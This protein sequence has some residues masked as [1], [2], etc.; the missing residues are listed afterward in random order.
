[1]N[2]QPQKKQ[3]R[4]KSPT[5]PAAESPAQKEARTKD[6]R[7]LEVLRDS[8]P[9][10]KIQD[11]KH[12]VQVFDQGMRALF[13]NVGNTSKEDLRLAKVSA[14]AVA[15]HKN[16]DLHNVQINPEK[17]SVSPERKGP[18]QTPR[19]HAKKEFKKKETQRGSS[20]DTDFSITV[21]RT[22]VPKV[23]AKTRPNET[24]ALPRN[25]AERE[26]VRKIDE[27]LDG[28]ALAHMEPDKRNEIE[29]LLFHYDLLIDAA[30]G[31]E[32]RCNFKPIP[33]PGYKWKTLEFLEEFLAKNPG[34]H[35][36]IFSVEHKGLG[37][38]CFYIDDL[39][40]L[41]LLKSRSPTY[42]ALKKLDEENWDTVHVKAG[43]ITL[44]GAEILLAI[45]WAD[46][47]AKFKELIKDG[48]T[49]EMHASLLKVSTAIVPKKRLGKWRTY[50]NLFRRT[51]R[52][53]WWLFVAKL[54]TDI[55]SNCLCVFVLH[56][57]LFN[58]AG[59]SMGAL[60]VNACREYVIGW[61]IQ[62]VYSEIWK[63]L[64]K[65]SIPFLTQIGGWL[66]TLLKK[67]DFGISGDIFQAWVQAFASQKGGAVVSGAKFFVTAVFSKLLMSGVTTLF[68]GTAFAVGVFSAGTLVPIA[69]GAL[70][71]TYS[72]WGSSPSQ[73]TLQLSAL[74]PHAANLN[75]I[76]L[77]TMQLASEGVCQ[78]VGYFASAKT[79][80]WCNKKSNDF[81]RSMFKYSIFLTVAD[82]LVFLVR[83]GYGDKKFW[84]FYGPT[85]C[86]L[87]Y[88][89]LLLKREQQM[90]EAVNGAVEALSEINERRADLAELEH[91]KPE[92][93]SEQYDA[94]LS[95]LNKEINS[96]TAKYESN[97]A[98]M[99]TVQGEQAH[100]QAAPQ[101]DSRL[102]IEAIVSQKLEKL[103]DKIDEMQRAS[104]AA[105]DLLEI[106]PLQQEQA[107]L[108][109]VATE[110]VAQNLHQYM[111]G[112]T[113][114]PNQLS[115]LQR[116]LASSIATL[117]SFEGAIA[118]THSRVPHELIRQKRAD[119][120]HNINILQK[121]MG[122]QKDES[123]N[124]E[125]QTG[126]ELMLSP[127]WKWPVYQFL[128]PL[129]PE[130]G[131]V[132]AIIKASL[133]DNKGVSL[134][135]F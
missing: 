24:G 103:N 23:K 43:G 71:V 10:E 27:A 7:F 109:R 89:N 48:M 79:V 55:L 54:A 113:I 92:I 32:Y 61:A 50:T 115:E 127:G 60:F 67:L 104:G 122:K 44:S 77:L 39:I 91:K 96:I 120:V 111:A 40:Q 110:H 69:L 125:K 53:M 117:K 19:K 18:V 3:S 72:R 9:P 46:A 83:V 78:I 63:I 128:C 4:K 121:R 12:K 133:N 42:D 25:K 56:Y 58:T 22:N 62:V 119:A 15:R 30:R 45:Q 129:N 118:T 100:A 13:T 80:R 76:N 59:L 41:L 37:L 98:E 70:F 106:V 123:K 8:E 112:S 49:P 35:L 74:T 94:K 47:Y 99:Q 108:Q 17:Q 130:P 90:N 116:K 95:L 28:Y 75:A 33:I 57:S 2:R 51:M 87:Q 93:P 38:C 26:T 6:E 21:Q 73:E 126:Y 34:N 86:E 66:S 101:V 102:T 88:D 85:R 134:V 65:F 105:V 64:P 114:D 52:N 68:S 36:A 132:C 124:T 107:M 14:T 82:M 97:L 11:I 20:K 81:I 131:S 84:E 16:L 5:R 31:L 29:D 135:T 1:M